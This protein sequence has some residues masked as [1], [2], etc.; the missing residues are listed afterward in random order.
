LIPSLGSEESPVTE[1]VDFFQPIPPSMNESR[2]CE[3]PVSTKLVSVLITLIR[4]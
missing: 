3:N 2:R 4:T 1:V